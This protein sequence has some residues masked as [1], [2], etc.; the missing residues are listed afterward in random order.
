MYM[1]QEAIDVHVHVQVTYCKHVFWLHCLVSQT[2]Y[3]Y[4]HIPWLR[5]CT[6][7]CRCVASMC[8]SASSQHFY[9]VATNA[10]NLVINCLLQALAA[11]VETRL[12]YTGTRQ[13]LG[14]L[15]LKLVCRIYRL[16]KY[17][18]FV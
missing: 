5:T 14:L 6:C 3:M 1:L 7:T 15:K 18:R 8:L 17:P 11:G 4:I 16:E 9:T 13:K 12:T 2:M 10:Q